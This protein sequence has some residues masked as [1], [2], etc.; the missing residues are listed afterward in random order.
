MA[1]VNGHI[2]LFSGRPG[3]YKIRMKNAQ[4]ELSGHGP[5]PQPP[6][7]CLREVEPGFAREMWRQMQKPQAWASV[8]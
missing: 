6:R 8:G 2:F 5:S 7:G 3:P 4:E 1:F